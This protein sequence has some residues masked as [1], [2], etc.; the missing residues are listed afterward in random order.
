VVL[1]A[2]VF[3]AVSCCAAGATPRYATGYCA[4]A[5]TLAPSDPAAAKAALVKAGLINSHN[6][7]IEKV[8]GELKP[9]P[10]SWRKTV[11]DTIS[12]W[13]TFF[14]SLALPALFALLIAGALLALTTYSP[15]VRRLGRRTPG[16]RRWFSARVA[17]DTLDDA[18]ATGF[19]PG[20]GALIANALDRLTRL[21]AQSGEYTIDRASGVESAADSVAVLADISPRFKALGSV[22]TFL[23]RA[24]ALP[25]YKLAGALQGAG[26]L[27]SGLT[28][29]L[30]R[31][32]QTV[33][34]ATF[35]RADPTTADAFQHLAIVAAGWIDFAVRRQEGFDDLAFDTS[36]VSF[37]HFRAGVAYELLERPEDAKTAYLQALSKDPTN[38]G[39]LMNLGR[40][41]DRAGRPDE[42]E[43]M[44][45][46][47]L[48]AL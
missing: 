38:V 2:A 3:T 39:A 12:D 6:P 27:G 32:A 18:G 46:A 15:R 9:P 16:L 29:A 31:R 36:G 21:G 33:D 41:Y 14:G 43:T 10:P 13:S 23:G 44:L 37:A 5:H 25:R 19:G 28:L 20:T 7:C 35:W 30:T 11:E 26:G 4:L 24:A 8:Q 48:L 42:A 22:L 40:I 17:L 1:V 34:G 47:A 45:T